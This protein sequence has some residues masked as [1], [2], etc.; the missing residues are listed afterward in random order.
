MET[1]PPSERPHSQSMTRAADG[2]DALSIHQRAGR[3]PRSRIIVEPLVWT[4]LQ[5]ELLHCSFFGPFPAPPVVMELDNPDG[6]RTQ[7]RFAGNFKDCLTPSREWA[8]KA[9]LCSSINS[10][11]RQNDDLYFIVGGYRRVLL[12]CQY[13]SIGTEYGDGSGP[14]PPVAAHIDWRRLAS[15]RMRRIAQQCVGR[16]SHQ[17]SLAIARLRLKHVWTDGQLN[18]PYV[19]AL[20]IA[21][22]EAQWWSIG[23]ENR[24]LASGVKPK[25][26]YTT[27]D[28]ESIY[29]YSANISSAFISMLY[30]PKTPPT[31]PQPLD[32]QITKIACEPLDTL[33]NRLFALIFSTTTPQ[34][35]ATSADLVLLAPGRRRPHPVPRQRRRTGANLFMLCEL[36]ACPRLHAPTLERGTGKTFV[37]PTLSMMSRASAVCLSAMQQTH[38]Q[39]HREDTNDARLALPHLRLGPLRQRLHTPL[40][41]C[42]VRAK[43]TTTKQKPGWNLP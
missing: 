10:P 30:D 19:V 36:L 8:M 28:D 12:P 15:S 29:L 11:L 16:R 31:T 39:L 14:R 40:T 41:G 27:K 1:P 2:V 17:S 33:R 23:E 35:M 43:P 21:I 26:L 3:Y 37:P 4:R 5:L 32:I 7:S 9:I 18:E 38:V 25:V 20:L 13:F 42:G 24:K 34:D 22:A 6:E